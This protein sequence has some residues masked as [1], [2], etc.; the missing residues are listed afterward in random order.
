[1]GL[2]S[3]DLK[4]VIAIVG[5]VIFV[6][7]A[8][9][10][11][12]AYTQDTINE[13]EIFGA[14]KTASIYDEKYIKHDDAD[15]MT[16]ILD[17]MTN[18]VVINRHLN[19]VTIGE[20]I[21]K[22]NIHTKAK[23]NDVVKLLDSWLV[24]FSAIIRLN[25]TI[26]AL[27]NKFDS[28]FSDTSRNSLMKC[29]FSVFE[30]ILAIYYSTGS[31]VTIKTPDV[32]SI[33]GAG[34]FNIAFAVRFDKPFAN[35]TGNNR[36]PFINQVVPNA[37]YVLKASQVDD[38]IIRKQM[39]RSQ[40]NIATPANEEQRV[41]L[42]AIRQA[43]NWF[44]SINYQTSITGV[45]LKAV[46]P[47]LSTVYLNGAHLI[48]S[49]CK[50]KFIDYSKFT[51]A[52]PIRGFWSVEE[53]MLPINYDKLKPNPAN[54]D[55]L[56]FYY[57]YLLPYLQ[58]MLDFN[59]SLWEDLPNNKF[60]YLDWKIGNIG[61]L[62]PQQG[63]R[64]TYKII[65]TELNGI[66]TIY[67]ENNKSIKSISLSSTHY[68]DYTND[69]K[70]QYEARHPGDPKLPD[71]STFY[72]QL[73][74]RESSLQIALRDFMSILRNPTK[75][76]YRSNLKTLGRPADKHAYAWGANVNERHKRGQIGGIADV[77]GWLHGIIKEGESFVSYY[78]KDGCLEIVKLPVPREI[79]DQLKRL[80][81][82]C[83]FYDYAKKVYKC[84]EDKDI[85]QALDIEE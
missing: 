25:L 71:R 85:M 36:K 73:H 84:V 7:I 57:Q 12:F 56:N 44:A 66:F 43:K 20:L 49:E 68:L 10:L 55:D 38:Y 54:P 2:I 15:D 6:Y 61:Y 76:T 75:D 67:R 13:K 65:D 53:F 80:V 45:D 50:K 79:V 47:Y 35:Q 60:S 18:K 77:T 5:V 74:P 69:I 19:R 16:N 58:L 41:K 33:L 59:E 62:E 82:T 17:Y 72:G 52:T 27:G 4:V 40:N 51:L 11:L 24:L 48:T 26:D 22:I 8:L 3:K 42:S 63:G 46:E 23:V 30:A 78:E 14:Y 28:D 29:K 31:S 9:S 34:A 32:S 21:R 81:D 1:M 70:Q 83:K 64:A 37:T 39:I